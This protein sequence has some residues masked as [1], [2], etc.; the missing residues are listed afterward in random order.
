METTEKH[1]EV[2]GKRTTPI[3]NRQKLPHSS[4]G[5]GETGG[6]APRARAEAASCRSHRGAMIHHFRLLEMSKMDSAIT[7]SNPKSQ[8]TF[9]IDNSRWSRFLL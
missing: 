3:A 6:A 5:I 4:A 8:L 9:T 1:K 2:R 7:G